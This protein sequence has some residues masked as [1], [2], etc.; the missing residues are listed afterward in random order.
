MTP[1]EMANTRG[2]QWSGLIEDLPPSILDTRVRD[3]PMSVI[4]KLGLML[5][6]DG[7][8][9]AGNWE[10]LAEELGVTTNAELEEIRR[11]A[12]VEQKFPGCRLLCDWMAGDGK[13][14]YVLLQALKAQNRQDCLEYLIQKCYGL[15]SMDLH[16]KIEFDMGRYEF[17]SVS[18]EMNASLASSLE[19]ILHHL[20]NYVITGPDAS[21]GWNTP[22][23]QLKG[24]QL[25]LKKVE[26]TDVT[27]HTVY[28]RH[29][30]H[31]G[32]PT[33]TSYLTSSQVVD[34]NRLDQRLSEHRL[35][36]LKGHDQT[37]CEVVFNIPVS[38]HTVVDN[39]HP[40]ASA[41]PSSVSYNNLS[42]CKHEI[43]STA[44]VA[45]FINHTTPK[46]P[47]VS[48]S[49]TTPMHKC[50]N[51]LT[52]LKPV[53]ADPSVSPQWPSLPMD[54]SFLDHVNQ[55]TQQTVVKGVEGHLVTGDTSLKQLVSRPAYSVVPKH[56]P[57]CI[58]EH[59][60]T[61]NPVTGPMSVQQF[62]AKNTTYAKPSTQLGQPPHPVISSK[63]T[64]PMPTV[65]T[66]SK[67]TG[68]SST[69]P[70][71]HDFNRSDCC[72]ANRCTSGPS[73]VA[74]INPVLGSQ[75]TTASLMTCATKT[76]PTTACTFAHS[77]A[78]IGLDH[79]VISVTARRCVPPSEE[80]NPG[81][82]RAAP[83][84][85]PGAMVGYP[86][87]GPGSSVSSSPV[88]YNL[89]E[90]NIVKTNPR[91]CTYNK[92]PDGYVELSDDPQITG[93]E[94][95]ESTDKNSES[96]NKVSECII[97]KSADGYFGFADIGDN[98]G[99]QKAS[100]SD[101]SR[102]ATSSDLNNSESGVSSMECENAEAASGLVKSA[103]APLKICESSDGYFGFA[104]NS[105]SPMESDHCLF[106]MEVSQS[107]SALTNRDH[108]RC[109]G[110]DVENHSTQ[111]PASSYTR[112]Q[113]A[114]PYSNKK[115]TWQLT[116]SS[117]ANENDEEED[118]DYLDMNGQA[119]AVARTRQGNGG[120]L[121]AMHSTGSL[122]S[123]MM[124]SQYEYTYIKFDEDHP[125]K[126]RSMSLP[127][128][129]PPLP[130]ERT[131]C[132][133]SSPIAGG[134][135][136]AV[137]NDKIPGW[138]PD[139]NESTPPSR[140]Q[141]LLHPRKEHQQPGTLLHFQV[142]QRVAGSER[143]DK[144]LPERGAQGPRSNADWQ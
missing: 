20:P 31:V 111:Q 14:V 98:T 1:T 51:S 73:S 113:C 138:C 96:A 132:M 60:M 80:H 86:H 97:Q 115:V 2:Q 117:I 15:H 18:T 66:H 133:S 29:T 110:T 49:S 121:F 134:R 39:T 33:S 79:P 17:K 62:L 82:D 38:G 72:N 35:D 142:W 116:Y 19:N 81:Q 64:V 87:R 45:S 43:P 10:G 123:Q 69:K 25:S 76:T 34:L 140:D 5:Y 99:P 7:R 28:G 104:G 22:A 84:A 120:S 41:P 107:D 70:A 94:V 90:E 63:P 144:P 32:V 92:R 50:S 85:G 88:Y 8:G 9:E 13:T 137:D 126:P 59:F 55:R 105:E 53:F 139:E 68:S 112:V 4:D 127:Q 61:N 75:S 65:V 40:K 100:Q 77:P 83:P 46:H 118:A 103:S 101:P 27:R 125:V 48:N 91:P 102:S 109:I 47:F 71:C 136:N 122:D 3:F 58:K 12:H 54:E 56:N 57:I 11:R 6:N 128:P 78:Y 93:M 16:V 114:S 74:N 124:E 108:D 106:A 119:L 44:C 130:M 36:N 131:R 129:S 24:K 141:T 42:G 21:I 95:S 52:T 143:A 30:Q 23:R 89:V 37:A 67:M 135:P 26:A